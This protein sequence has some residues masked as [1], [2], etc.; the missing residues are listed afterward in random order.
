[1]K[2]RI[3]YRPNSPAGTRR[4]ATAPNERG[5]LASACRTLVRD[6]RKHWLPSGIPAA[7]AGQHCRGRRC[8]LKNI[9]SNKRA[10]PAL[11]IRP[12]KAHVLHVGNLAKLAAGARPGAAQSTVL[13]KRTP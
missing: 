2:V 8:R 4:K 5:F 9:L 7:L 13:K 3:K 11:N 12:P 6:N 10:R 1:M